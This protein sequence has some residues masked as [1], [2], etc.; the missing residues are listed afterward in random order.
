M[1]L[2]FILM[3]GVLN[4]AWFQITKCIPPSW[5]NC[6]GKMIFY[7]CISTGS[8]SWSKT[9]AILGEFARYHGAAFALQLVY[10][11]LISGILFFIVRAAWLKWKLKRCDGV[12]IKVDDCRQTIPLGQQRGKIAVPQLMLAP[13]MGTLFSTDHTIQFLKDGKPVLSLKVQIAQWENTQPVTMMQGKP[14]ICSYGNQVVTL[15]TE[16]FQL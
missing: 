14:F 8:L 9:N 4:I 10:G 2:F 16:W 15:P 3:D 11:L 1:S 5:L 7:L 12:S 6:Q 13:F